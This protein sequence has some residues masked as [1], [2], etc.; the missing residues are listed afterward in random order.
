MK[1]TIEER[2]KVFSLSKEYYKRCKDR[3]KYDKIV[4]N[5]IQL[6]TDKLIERIKLD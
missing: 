2:A 4:D 3:K 6:M 5:L 1:I